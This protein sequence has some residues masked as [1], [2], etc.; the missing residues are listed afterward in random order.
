MIV[1]MRRTDMSAN[2][3]PER[4]L[5]V[6]AHR[7][8]EGGAVELEAERGNRA[9]GYRERDV[10]QGD[11]PRVRLT[12]YGMCGIGRRGGASGQGARERERPYAT[13]SSPPFAS[14]CRAAT[15]GATSP[16][17]RRAPRS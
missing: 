3:R 2:H 13:A 15:T 17:M 1:T 5:G 7:A 16:V 4:P 8:C 9:P 12:G 14:T 10:C 6:P 11:E